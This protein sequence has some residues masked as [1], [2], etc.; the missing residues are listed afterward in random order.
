MKHVLEH[1]KRSI[2]IQ[3]PVA[4]GKTD[5]YAELARVWV[6]RGKR[7]LVLAHREELIIQGVERLE[8]RGLATSTIRAN[9]RHLEDPKAR[10]QVASVQTLCRR[11]NL[12]KA[13]VIIVDE[14]HH[15]PAKSYMAILA[16]YPRARVIGLS[17]TPTYN[18]FRALADVFEDIYTTLQPEEAV[19]RGY[20]APFTGRVWA[21]PSLSDVAKSGGDFEVKS[22]GEAMSRRHI[23]GD[24]V[25]AWKKRAQGVSTILFAA[26]R[27]QSQTMVKAFRAKGVKAEYLDGETRPEARAATLA[28]FKAGEFHVLCNVGL[29]TEG[30]NI[31]RAKCII[32]ARPTYSLGLYLQMVGRGRRPWNGE[33]CAIHDHGGLVAHHGLPDAARD[34]KLGGKSEAKRV[35]VCPRCKTARPI[36]SGRC[37]GCPRVGEEHDEVIDPAWIL[38]GYEYDMEQFHAMRDGKRQEAVRRYLAG[39]PAHVVA[40]SMGVATKKSVLDWVR[41]V[42]GR[43]RTQQESVSANPVIVEEAHRLW[44]SGMSCRQIAAALGGDATATAVGFWS[45]RHKWVKSRARREA[46]AALRAPDPRLVAKAKRLYLGGESLFRVARRIGYKSSVPVHRWATAGGWVRS[47]RAAALLAH[48]NKAP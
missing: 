44:K 35:I 38:H 5:I 6:A 33:T 48:K 18:G 29:F 28:R 14:A 39:E 4:T 3:S 8:A 46:R 43:V 36:D 13:D 12:P 34:W 1:P 10:V 17:A 31:E 15:T 20:L 25:R 11:D 40:K 19:E 23:V 30:T 45:R 22:L 2:L 16:N 42:G 21:P 24:I 41:A 9:M 37:P 47:P 27:K 26:T 32:L 7:V